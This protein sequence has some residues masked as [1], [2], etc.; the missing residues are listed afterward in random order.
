MVQ[1]LNMKKIGE[2]FAGVLTIV[3]LYLLINKYLFHNNDKNNL[4]N[5]TERTINQYTNEQLRIENIQKNKLYTQKKRASLKIINQ[6]ELS[7]LTSKKEWILKNKNY[8][9]QYYLFIKNGQLAIRNNDSNRKFKVKLNGIGEF[10]SFNGEALLDLPVVPSEKFRIYEQEDYIPIFGYHYVIPDSQS[11]R[12]SRHFLEMHLSDFQ[13][14]ITALNDQMNCHWITFGNVMEKYIIS[15]QK[16]PRNACVVTFDDG[17]IDSY[18]YIFPVLKR[19]HIPA[20]FYIITDLVGKR[21]YV[22]WQNLDKMYRNGSEMGA[23]TLFSQGL[24]NTDWYEKKYRR[25]FTHQELVHQIKGSKEALEKQ[26]FKVNTFAYP[27]GEWNDEIIKIIKENNFI[28]TRDTLKDHTY[29]DYR[30]LAA[31]LNNEFIWHMN[32][33]KPELET[34][35][36]LIKKMK[37]TGWWQF[38]EGYQ[39]NNNPNKDI[40]VLSSLRHLTPHTFGVLSLPKNKDSISK[41]F[42]L[43]E[44]GNFTMDI[45]ALTGTKNK[46]PYSKLSNIKIKIDQK[47]YT[48][49]AGNISNCKLD[50]NQ[51]YCHFFIDVPLN[52]GEHFLT[53]ENNNLNTINLDKFRMF[54]EMELKKEYKMSI[55]E[56]EK[57]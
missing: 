26:G 30:P 25:K 19:F 6:R 38:E 46:G 37:Y 45:F 2:V 34:A 16:L 42:L 41:N 39:I 5:N 31:S 33:F 43:G 32:Y 22:T 51:Y 24:V 28:A 10:K 8:Q 54:R 9:A 47:D 23:H 49:R 21:G 35:D 40:H 29:L 1:R 14:Q 3:I 7:L 56:Y 52:K 4:V 55:I 15:K 44:D 50:R 12:S 13:K 18:K 57:E 48:P 27:L 36:S 17:H 20:T 11:I 53:V